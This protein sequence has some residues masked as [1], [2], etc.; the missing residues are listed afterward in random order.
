MALSQ[1]QC[2]NNYHVN[3]RTNESKPEFLYSEKQ[4]L[5]LEKLLDEGPDSFQEFIH[6]NRIR[7]FLS[8]LEL[9]HLST[10]VEPY[11]S[12]GPG[13]LIG[14]DGDRTESLQYWPERSDDSLPQLDLGWPERANYRGVTRVAVHAQPPLYGD[15]HVKEVIRRIIARAKKVIA[16][17]MDLFTDVD[18]FKD[19]LYASIK[20]NVAVYIILDI[21]GVPHFLKMCE[22]ASMHA[23]HLKNLRV[24]SIR[25]PGFC[26][27]SSKKVCGSQ[28][29]KFM[30]VDG[31]KAVSGSYS[32]T[33]TASRLDRSIITVLTGQAV[34]LFDQLF[35][36]LYV[37]SYVVDLNKIN[38]VKEQK[39]EP[40]SKSVP[41]L[42]PSTTLALKLINPKYA[43]VS[44][45]ATASSNP[46]APETFREKSDIIKQIEEV[47][48]GLHIHPGL[49][50]LE[51]A[52][53]IDYLPVW[54]EPEPPSD[55]IGFINIRNCNKPLQ[56]HL[57]RSEQYEISQ[58][59]RFKDPIHAPQK[60]Q[61]LCPT[62]TS[63]NA[64]SVNEHPLIQPQAKQKK[65][66]KPCH[67]SQQI[68]PTDSL[69]EQ[70]M[71]LLTIPDPKSAH[72]SQR[73][74]E[75]DPPADKMEKQP[76]VLSKER[77]KNIPE[78]DTNTIK[79]LDSV[80]DNIVTAQT[81][82]V[83]LDTTSD[84]QS[85]ENFAGT[86]SNKD[87][88][89]NQSNTNKL[90][91]PDDGGRTYSDS[92]SAF[93]SLK[94][95]ECGESVNDDQKSDVAKI[96]SFPAVSTLPDESNSGAE[97]L[98]LLK[99]GV[100]KNVSNHQIIKEI[101]ES[102]VQPAAPEKSNVQQLSGV[103]TETFGF[104]V[105]EQQ[106]MIEETD[107]ILQPGTGGKIPVQT[108]AQVKPDENPEFLQECESHT[109][110]HHMLDI[111][112]VESCDCAEL[113]P[114]VNNSLLQDK[115]ADPYAK[116]RKTAEDQRI[117]FSD[118][119]YKVPLLR[120]KPT[121]CS[122]FEYTSN[123]ESVFGK[124]DTRSTPSSK[125]ASLN[126]GLQK[127]KHCKEKNYYLR[128]INQ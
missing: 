118:T 96:N 73:D 3:L 22:S 5:A 62:S 122:G 104:I 21:T 27:H 42:Q 49:M 116:V 52:N 57:T 115:E 39:V 54:P 29:Q 71:R 126:N 90:T 32:F 19:L 20:R 64:A 1:L 87:L 107:S 110:L 28:S 23:G 17:V 85:G 30:F 77:E 7:P 70:A 31:D 46:V 8:D 111:Q 92:K 112:P 40:V 120:I 24:R 88:Q 102:K 47:P 4:R 121:L 34:D 99:S 74:E 83:Q 53:M 44:G 75:K 59:I 55:V 61:E 11:C 97:S 50:H 38:L 15:A 119:D 98:S 41:A 114:L 72:K 108:D 123:L 69:K 76:D 26:T 48:K 103:T 78:K 106:N 124:N 14:F 125:E 128:K 81:P 25:G 100:S 18:I 66:N 86:I 79:L 63:L 37:M 12:D 95:F 94:N 117:V 84:K 80:E 56:A 91:Q 65:N 82:V 60:L 45:N 43:L 16:V 89:D 67:P 6:T 35:Q 2:L 33:W 51:K 109:G 9:A 13:H 36:D 10:S 68:F 113:P 101:K 127:E 58:A 93:L 105:N